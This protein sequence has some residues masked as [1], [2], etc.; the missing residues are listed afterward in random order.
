MSTSNKTTRQTS[1]TNDIGKHPDNG[2]SHL[3]ETHSKRDLKLQAKEFAENFI[4]FSEIEGAIIRGHILVEKTLNDTI[5]LAIV[6]K[7]EY[8]PEKFTF[9]RKLDI[10][11]MLGICVPFK[12]EINA[13]NKLRNQVAHS[14]QY[15]EKY[16]DL[17]CSSMAKIDNNDIYKT[18]NKLL[19]F[20]RAISFLA[21]CIFAGYEISILKQS[22]MGIKY[23]KDNFKLE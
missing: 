21:G 9:T 22:V 14:L 3:I 15:E 19:I 20:N 17:I 1:T 7:N 4:P 5:K 16:I 6:Q 2:S 13:L 11:N 12:K 8:E 18:N 10:A 23:A